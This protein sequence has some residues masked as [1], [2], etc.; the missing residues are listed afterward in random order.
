MNVVCLPSGHSAEAVTDCMARQLFPNTIN[1]KKKNQRAQ[2]Y[3]PLTLW[4]FKPQSDPHMWL[5]WW[6]LMIMKY[7]LKPVTEK[8]TRIL[9]LPCKWSK[10]NFSSVQSEMFATTGAE[11]ALQ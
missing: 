6:P 2:A 1:K 10:G 8:V 4:R 3:F 11:S 7:D 9:S 5:E